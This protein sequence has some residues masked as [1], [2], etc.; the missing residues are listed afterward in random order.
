MPPTAIDLR[1]APLQLLT[2]RLRLE[3]PAP[4]HAAAFAEGVAASAEALG[5][6]AWTSRP[7]DLAWATRFCEDDARSREAGLDLAFHVLHRDTGAWVGRIDLH[8]I[9]FAAAR[10]EIG[11]VGDLRH[12]GQGLMREAVRAVITLCFSLGFERVEAMSDARN[13]RALHFADATGLLQREGVLRRHERDL[14]GQPCDMVL[15]AALNPR[16]PLPLPPDPA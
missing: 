11:Y 15:W 4:R 14:Q 10:G 5:F 12:S 13:T 1:A 8:S 7:R 16:G 2:P 9:D 3:A 6:I